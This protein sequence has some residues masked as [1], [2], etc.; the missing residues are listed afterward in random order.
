MATPS[1]RP[2]SEKREQWRAS[3]LGKDSTRHSPLL[4]MKRVPLGELIL[5]PLKSLPP[6]GLLRTARSV[7][8][9]AAFKARFCEHLALT[10]FYVAFSISH[11]VFWAADGT[12]VVPPEP[13]LSR[14][15]ILRFS[16]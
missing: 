11:L 16:V 8:T 9:Q 15:R 5:L 13:R 2:I 3:K 10:A 7:P 12:V 6:I 14:P 4:V 1:G